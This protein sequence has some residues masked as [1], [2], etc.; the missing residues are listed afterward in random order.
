MVMHRQ[1]RL[2]GYYLKRLLGDSQ[3]SSNSSSSRWR[4]CA[5]ADCGTWTFEGLRGQGVGRSRCQGVGRLRG[6][7]V[8]RSKGQGVGG[9]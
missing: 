4:T 1:Q 7:R 2:C 8:V 5:G 3:A 9:S 6:H